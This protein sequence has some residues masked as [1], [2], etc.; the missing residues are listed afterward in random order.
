MRITGV[1]LA[2]LPEIGSAVRILRSCSI[3]GLCM[4]FPNS[5]TLCIPDSRSRLSALQ[6]TN[7]DPLEIANHLPDIESAIENFPTPGNATPS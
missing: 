5:Q 7:I 1:V 3:V 2:F 6:Q 4:P